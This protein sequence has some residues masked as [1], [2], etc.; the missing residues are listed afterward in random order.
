MMTTSVSGLFRSRGF[1]LIELM[2][3]LTIFS[4]L[5]GIAVPNLSELIR[6]NAIAS[7]SNHFSAALS[8]ARSEAVKRNTRVLVCKRNTAGTACDNSADWE[9]GWI[10]FADNDGDNAVDANEALGVIDPL[11]NGYTLRPS[12][13]INWLAYQSDGRVRQNN[14]SS[15]ADAAVFNGVTFR[16]CGDDA[17][18]TRS[19]L[20]AINTVGR[21]RLSKGTASCP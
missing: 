17:D 3:T 14:A 19:R 6:A 7:Q 9:D 15:S 10:I 5:L 18:N 2:I 11:R 12:A 13:A 20:L 1:S 8:L 4:I 16:L 21:A